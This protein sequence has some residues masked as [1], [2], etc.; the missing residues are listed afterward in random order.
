MV[1]DPTG[2]TA[3]C[4]TSFNVTNDPPSITSVTGPVSAIAIGTSASVTAQFT[5][6]GTQG[7]TCK[8]TWD[9][10]SPD[11]TVTVGSGAT[12][13]TDSHVYT[14]ASVNTV[15][16]TVTD[17]CLAASAAAAYQFVVVYDPSAGFVTGGGF[18]VSPAGAY[19]ANTSLT[20]K[21]NFGFVSKY[22]KGAKVPTGETEF[23]FQVAGFN[24]H[25]TAY[26]WLVVSGAKAQ[27]KGTGT[28][29]NAGNYGFLLTATDG[30]LTGGGGVDKFRIKIWD[31]NAAGAIVYDNNYGTS[32]DIDL[33]NPQAI[34]GGS[35]VIHQK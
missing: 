9:D 13:C 25:S 12:S 24:F 27:Y 5:D 30:D 11:T 10:G 22:Q 19:R 14:S 7:H 28:V 18:I 15:T 16:V 23:Q 6:T 8:F 4:V 21:A 29:N 3:S 33:A 2:N 17:D 34:S 26:E 31:N 1:A 35:I 32:D 20:G